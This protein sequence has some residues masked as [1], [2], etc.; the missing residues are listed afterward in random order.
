MAAERTD[1]QRICEI[2]GGTISALS[3]SGALAVAATGITL[4]STLVS[5]L[6][7]GIC[8]GC[9]IPFW[10]EGL[11]LW[12]PDE[13]LSRQVGYRF[14]TSGED[15]TKRHWPAPWLV[16]G[17][18]SADPIIADTSELQCPVLYSIHGQGNWEPMPF[19]PSI[20]AFFAALLAWLNVAVVKFGGMFQD[21]ESEPLPEAIDEFTKAVR[22]IVGE[23]CLPM[24]LGS[25]WE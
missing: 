13:L 24:W 10:G 8:T 11:E 23:E 3:S 18:N 6:K 20:D 21:H 14:S 12:R 1:M 7:K 9:V 25:G 4:P 19:A 15:L 5:Q 17:S 22:P 16:L 2:T